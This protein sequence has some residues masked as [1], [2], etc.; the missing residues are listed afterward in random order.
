MKRELI[1]PEYILTIMQRLRA[2]GFEAFVVGGAVR[3]GLTG[4]VPE[5]FDLCTSALPTETETVFSGEKVIRTGIRHGTVTVLSDGRPVEITTY[6][7]EG[8]YSDGRHPDRV[9]FVANLREDLG[10]RDFTVNAMAYSPETGVVDYFGGLE[11]LKNRV[12]R[13]VG[14]PDRRFFEDGLRI[15]R[16]LRF[17][18]VK[19]FQAAEDLEK[20]IHRCAPMLEKVAYE[21]IDT[22]LLKFLEGGRA[23]ELLDQYR[24]VFALLIPEL[25]GMYD[26]DQKS[27]YH[28]RDVWHHTLAAVRTIRPDPQL[29][30]TMLLHDIAKPVV[31][32]EDENGR[33][34]FKGHQKRGSEMAETI[35]KRMKFPNAFIAETVTLVREHDLKLYADRPLIRRCLNRLGEDLLRKL[36]EV[37]MADASGK[38]EKY[39][40][41]TAKRL[42]EVRNMLD[43]VLSEGDCFQLSLLA[44][45]GRDL[46]NAGFQEGHRIGST[47]TFLLEEVMEDHLPNEKDALLAAAL[48]REQS[49]RKPV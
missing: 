9:Q 49:C 5:D 48:K 26:F 29:R 32:V 45:N 13:C 46:K 36:L 19:G 30:M 21:R 42:A 6:R 20:A 24:D 11:D 23:A 3:D 15:M 43:Q 22:E 41:P 18:S 35:L 39:V 8:A 44:V 47:L 33:G 1:L 27:P 34:H 28:N 16:A 25:S 12:L 4:I 31:F 7:T 14:E 2:A 10:R 37:Q 40:A 17:L 38:Y